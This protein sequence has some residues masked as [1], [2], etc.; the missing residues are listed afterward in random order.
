[1]VVL[2][3]LLGAYGIAYGMTNKFAPVFFKLLRIPKEQWRSSITKEQ[4]STGPVRRFFVR[5]FACPYCTGFHAGWITY[6]FLVLNQEWVLYVFAAAASCY[7]ADA[8]ARKLE[9]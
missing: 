1:M 2:V 8:A 5:L 7:L 6:V 4:S 3:Y 9:R